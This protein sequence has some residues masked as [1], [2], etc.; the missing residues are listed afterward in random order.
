M[1]YGRFSFGGRVNLD[2]NLIFFYNTLNFSV[3]VNG[4]Y[5]IGTGV[6]NIDK[7]SE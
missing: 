1:G 6:S 3:D 5:N 4:E 7:K 2:M